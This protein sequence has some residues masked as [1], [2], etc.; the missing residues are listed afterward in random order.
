[1]ARERVD[2][3]ARRH[4]PDLAHIVVAAADAR[5]GARPV[6]RQ[7]HA[8]DDAAG[9]EDPRLADRR[10]V[11]EAARRRRRGIRKLGHAA[12][13]SRA[14]SQI[15]RRRNLRGPSHG[16]FYACLRVFYAFFTRS[17]FFF[18]LFIFSPGVR[19]ANGVDLD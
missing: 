13:K 9:V 7:R 1:M 4:V 12:R 14:R 11:V 17:F 16:V 10:P 6:A 19:D 15:T 3:G 5:R 8:V 18:Y 2:E